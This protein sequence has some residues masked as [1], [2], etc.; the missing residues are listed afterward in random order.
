MSWTSSTQLGRFPHRSDGRTVAEIQKNVI[1]QGKRNPVSRLFHAKEDKDAIAA[2]GK[3]LDRMLHI[4][5]VR[6]LSPV[7]WELLRAPVPDGA[8][9]K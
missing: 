3:D 4:F 5:N 9:N 8:V 2:W 6:S 1:K 7:R